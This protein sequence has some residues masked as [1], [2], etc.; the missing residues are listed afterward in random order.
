MVE[1]KHV[2]LFSDSNPG[3]FEHVT[4]IYRYLMLL[5]I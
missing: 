3:H 2:K 1:N 5:A 4:T